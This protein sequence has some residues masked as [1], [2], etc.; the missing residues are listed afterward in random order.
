MPELFEAA[1]AS[2][3]VKFRNI[4][5]QLDDTLPVVNGSFIKSWLSRA[6]ENARILIASCEAARGWLRR[7]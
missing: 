5:A 4:S 7:C 1:V 6:L 2:P 3:E